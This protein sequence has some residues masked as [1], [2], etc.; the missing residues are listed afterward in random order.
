MVLAVGEN[1]QMAHF[2]QDEDTNKA[3]LLLDEHL[4]CFVLHGHKTLW[5][6]QGK[7]QVQSDEGF[8]LAKGNYLRTERCIDPAMGYQSLVVRLSDEFLASVDD[9]GDGK[10]ANGVSSDGAPAV[11]GQA[12][13]QVFHLQEDV[14]VRGLVTQL[15]QYFQAPGE[16]ARIESL[17]PLKIREL[18][19]LLLSAGANRGFDNVIRRLPSLKE[20]SLSALMEA[21]FR[22]SLSLEQWAFLAGL[23]LSSFKRKFEAVFHMPPGRWIQQR[24]LEEAYHLLGH[25]RMNVTEVCFTVGFENLA[26]FVQAFKEKY[27]I[28]PKQRQ[29]TG[30]PAV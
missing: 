24:R 22:E 30:Q 23:S 18:L 29:M 28:T 12:P 26:H 20:P 10:T 3:N 14:L 25:R 21:H 27:H 7:L 2:R 19:T 16:K 9:V 1:I 5:H 6:S 4:L 17:L 13:D 15:T 11:A 8:F